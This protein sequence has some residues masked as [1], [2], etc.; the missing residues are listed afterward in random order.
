MRNIEIHASLGDVI[1]SIDENGDIDS[2]TVECVIITYTNKEANES[3]VLYTLGIDIES[4]TDL[5]ICS[6]LDIECKRKYNNKIFSTDKNEAI[7]ISNYIK[8]GIYTF[9]DF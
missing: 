3:D 1:Y 4:N 9:E 6:N 8:S 5:I 7:E 2:T